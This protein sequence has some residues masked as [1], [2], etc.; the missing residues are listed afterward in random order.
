MHD[1]SHDCLIIDPGCYYVNEQRTLTTYIEETNLKPVRLLN[2]H[3]H[4]DHVLGNHFVANT[5]HIKPEIHKS[6]HPLLLAAKEYAHLYNLEYQQ[7]PAPENYLE[8][9]AKIEFGQSILDI[10]FVPGHS[11][12]HIALVNHEQK[13][14]ISGDVLFQGSIGRTDLPG[15]DH[16][17]L[18]ASITSKLIPLGD[19]FHVYPGHGPSTNIAFEK[20]HNPFL[21]K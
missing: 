9:D 4:I 20:A 13:F 17:L 16:N 19:E 7:S 10:V 8:E 5:Y 2:T 6:E 15:G 12:G 21:I 3:C 11:P 18:M 14:V 1:E